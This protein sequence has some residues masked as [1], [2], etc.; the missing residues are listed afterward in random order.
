MRKSVVR[1]EKLLI[2]PEKDFRKL[3]I[4][5]VAFRGAFL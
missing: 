5:F 3:E 1:V 2:G 4:T